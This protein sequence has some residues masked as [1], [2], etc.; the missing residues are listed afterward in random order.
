MIK[1]NSE[2]TSGFDHMKEIL[3]MTKCQGQYFEVLKPDQKQQFIQA[4]NNET[5]SNN[6]MTR[7]INRFQLWIKLP[8][9]REAYEKFLDFIFDATK[10]S[11][12]KLE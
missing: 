3:A 2:V 10:V 4:V 12:K 8:N 7:I 9:L 5:V 1:E 6:R 11:G